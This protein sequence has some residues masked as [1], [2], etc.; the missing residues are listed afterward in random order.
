MG[1]VQAQAIM[2][3]DGYVAEQDNPRDAMEDV[4]TSLKAMRELST[5]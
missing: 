1:T 5:G 4:E 3:L 2:S